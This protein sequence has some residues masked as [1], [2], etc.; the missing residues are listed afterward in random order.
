MALVKTHIVHL[1]KQLEIVSETILAPEGE[2]LI[3]EY[4][5]INKG[6]ETVRGFDIEVLRKD[7]DNNYE[8]EGELVSEFYPVKEL[9]TVLDYYI[10]NGEFPKP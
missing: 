9:E 1:W 10:R 3:I 5:S 4:Y 6:N 2:K 8:E 7:D